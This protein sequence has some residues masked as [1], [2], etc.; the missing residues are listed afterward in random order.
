MNRRTLWRG[1]FAAGAIAIVLA[2]AVILRG[3]QGNVADQEAEAG[4]ASS[5]PT[6]LST[7]GRPQ[8]VEFFNHT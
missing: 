8:L 4:Y 5:D 7:T 3:S 2:L 6:L 1:T